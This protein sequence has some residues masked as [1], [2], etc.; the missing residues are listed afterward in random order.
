L[1]ITSGFAGKAQCCRLQNIALK[2]QLNILT[3]AEKISANYITLITFKEALQ[4]I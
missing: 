2:T 4:L 3:G 1:E